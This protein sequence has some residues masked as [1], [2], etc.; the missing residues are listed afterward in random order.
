[1][2]KLW[3]ITWISLLS[4]LGLLIIGV[5]VVCWI[6][7]SPSRLTPIVRDEAAK[8]LTCRSEVG[9]VELTFFKTFPRFC[10]RVDGVGLIN[11]VEGAPSDTLL[12]AGSVA[13][14]VD[15]AALLR[16]NELIVTDVTLSDARIL[17]YKNPQG[18]V[19]FD[20]MPADTVAT[21]AD[22]AALTL[23]FKYTDIDCIRLRG[24]DVRYVDDSSK[25]NARVAMLNATIKASGN[26]E[27]I[28]ATIDS[29]P[30]TLL[31]AM[32][33]G[34]EAMK[35]KATGL[36]LASTCRM[37]QDT[38]SAAL[39]IAPFA[40]SLEYGGDKYLDSTQVAVDGVV[41]M[42]LESGAI[43]LE[44]VNVA[45]GELVLG[46]GGSVT[47]VPSSDDINLDVA[48]NTNTW[49]IARVMELI[50]ESYASMVK[51]IKADGELSSW[52]TV[53]GVYND[54]NMPQLGIYLKIARAKVSYPEMIPFP[55]HD[56]GGQVFVSTDL[57][58]DKSSYV[59]IDNFNAS[60]PRSRVKTAGRID[61][62]FSDMSVDLNTDADLQLDEFQ[63]MIPDDLK[64]NVKG[65]LK[66]KVRS[67]FTMSQLDKMAIEKMKF[68][69]AL[70]A[71]DLDVVFDSLML[72]TNAADL[73][74]SLPNDKAAGSADARFVAASVNV[75][76]EL[77]ATMIDG[78]VATVRGA[79]IDLQAS[80]VRDTTRIPN[81]LCAFRMEGLVADLDSISMTLGAPSG[82]LSV[83]PQRRMAD[84][85][86]IGVDYHCASLRARLGNDHYSTGKVDMKADLLYDDSQKDIFLQWMPK[87]YFAMEG[88]RISMADLNRPVEL[89]SVKMDFTP[90]EFA[91]RE[92]R[93]KIDDSDF[94]LSGKLSNIHSYFKSDSLLVGDFNFTSQYTDIGKLMELT[95]GLGDQASVRRPA[96]LMLA[97]T[98]PTLPAEESLPTAYMVPKGIDM[99]LHLNIKRALWQ[100]DTIKNIKGDVKVYN[101]RLL[102]DNLNL[103]SPAADIQL[104]GL[105]RPDR[106]NHI[107]TGL[108]LSVMNIEIANLLKMV[109]SLDETMPMLRSFGGKA[110]FYVS[111]QT[112]IDSLYNMKMSTLNATA[113]ISGTNLVLM[114][115]E[116]FTEIAKMLMFS[117]KTQNKVDSLSAE[118]T[119]LRNEI[120]IYPFLVVMDK[121]K[122]VV[123][124][125]HNLDMTFNYN[126]AL[127]QSPLPFRLAASVSGNIDKLHYKLIKNPYSEFY[128]P[129]ARNDLPN[130]QMD[131]RNMIRQALL[132]KVKKE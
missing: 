3:K 112:Y 30:F 77:R 75:P 53:R 78:P 99:T 50:P 119:I 120:N 40:L 113:S 59:R 111:A 108:N 7:F 96:P 5:S 42:A 79:T 107:F 13:A 23:P 60:T 70:H 83:A 27:E 37:A 10:L 128:R 4:L 20:I 1:M 61:R 106:K 95:N 93:V 58:D 54:K 102:L 47:M 94:G 24:V 82:N 104:T 41:S 71:A 100:V 19:N 12:W 18:K 73:L 44:G 31:F 127:V 6:V 11:P 69:G 57:S 2:K 114:D 46:L 65:A 117:K 72:R 81:V 74:F 15:I 51:G 84:K 122:A 8:M 14:A 9:D 129:V 68:S 29:D 91:I 86:R 33:E 28:D 132:E 32:G 63:S 64:L 89:P 80:D 48:Y 85:P 92:A 36:S 103:T 25:M 39:G 126:I 52:G 130:K 55:L 76:G 109:P 110:E 105:Y 17:A 62:L 22:T 35:V 115:G 87:G 88:G 49:R 116:T 43:L 67:A 124:G 34:K 21:P 125:R 97:S 123:G 90:Q 66:G 56:V 101:G 38:V 118:F 131:L 98:S 45:L 26:G 16:R 121:Y